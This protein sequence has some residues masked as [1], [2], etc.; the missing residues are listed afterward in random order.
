ML[1]TSTEVKRLDVSSSSKTKEYLIFTDT[2]I[3]RVDSE[4]R[5]TPKK[6]LHRSKNTFVS[7]RPLEE[8][9]TGREAPLD[10]SF[11]ISELSIVNEHA[12][13]RVSNLDKQMTATE[14]KIDKLA[15]EAEEAS[16]LQPKKASRPQEKIEVNRKR[17]KSYYLVS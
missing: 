6:V 8:Q 15:I 5:D 12:Q 1:E 14:K 16:L 3:L 11:D 4:Q 10:E 7:E 17:I 13:I 9:I 2:S